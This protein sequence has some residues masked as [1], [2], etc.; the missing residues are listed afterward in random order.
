MK[1]VTSLVSLIAL[2]VMSFTMTSCFRKPYQEEKYVEIQPNQTA[3]VFPLES[4]N[5]EGQAKFN[6]EKY[7]DE[8]KVADKRIYIPTQWHQTGRYDN[9]GEWIPS[10]KIITVDRT[11]V[12]REW[13][14]T[15]TGTNT[16]KREELE[17]ES[18]ESIGFRVGITATAS[19]PEEWASKFLYNYNTRTLEQVMDNDVRGYV[20]NILTTEFGIRPLSQCQNDRKEIYENMRK[21]VTEHF[22]TLGV[23]IMNIGAA[24]QFGYID[25]TIQ[26]AINA[27]FTSESKVTEALNSVK[28]ANNFALAKNAI[29]DQKQLDADINIKNA[30]ADGIRSGKIP[31][32][33]TIGG[34]MSILDLYGLKGVSAQGSGKSK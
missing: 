25:Q 16:N 13:T 29:T 33:N 22:A 7:L 18:K 11:P 31:V 28:A 3:Y 9:D 20:Q 1:K 14:G 12:T 2:V 8:K 15:G 30:I 5:K 10:I 32:P 24:G 6:S 27:K 34:N 26:D 4:G 21:Q 23:K 19:I 17:V